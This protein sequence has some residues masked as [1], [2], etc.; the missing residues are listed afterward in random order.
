MEEKFDRQIN[1]GIILAIISFIITIV[2][3]ISAS[4]MRK[5]TEADAETLLVFILLLVGIVGTAYGLYMIYKGK[6]DIQL[7]ELFRKAK[8][9]LKKNDKTE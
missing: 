4:N 7:Q 3:T 2:T 5:R 1:N 9:E 6:K 8:E